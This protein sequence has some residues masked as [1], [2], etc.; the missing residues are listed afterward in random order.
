MKHKGRSGSPKITEELHDKG[1]SVSKNRVARRMKAAGL[2][3]IVRRKFKPTTDSK[4]S[5]PIAAN[6]LQRDFS[7]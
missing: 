3:S 1:F 6:L 5:H 7:T 2:R 4:H